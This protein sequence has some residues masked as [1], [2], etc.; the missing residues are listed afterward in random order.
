MS[1]TKE[2]EKNGGSTRSIEEQKWL[3]EYPEMK[4][5][6]AINKDMVEWMTEET[7]DTMG[8]RSDCG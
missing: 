8:P 3:R 2:K 1:S 5:W 6:A 7:S 4:I